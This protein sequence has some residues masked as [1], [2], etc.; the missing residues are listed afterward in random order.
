MISSRSP[1]LPSTLDF[2]SYLDISDAKMNDSKLFDLTCQ[3]K[4]WTVIHMVALTEKGWHCLVSKHSKHYNYKIVTSFMANN[5]IK[6]PGGPGQIDVIHRLISFMIRCTY[7]ITAKASWGFLGGIK[8]G[9]L[10]GNIFFWGG[11]GGGLPQNRPPGSPDSVC[12][13]VFIF[14]EGG[15]N[16]MGSPHITLEKIH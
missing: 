10:L 4:L 6:W 12:L 11:G 9:T 13:L 7:N 1:W 15:G 16:E 5:M 3:F 2:T 14:F 8:S